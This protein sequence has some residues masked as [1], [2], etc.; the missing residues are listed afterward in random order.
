MIERKLNSFARLTP[1]SKRELF[2]GDLESIVRNSFRQGK[3]REI[4]INTNIVYNTQLC[5][6]GLH[7]FA[8]LSLKPR[9]PKSLAR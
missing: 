2:V 4:Y 5:L 1:L 8:E 3:I 6:C 7:R 9:E